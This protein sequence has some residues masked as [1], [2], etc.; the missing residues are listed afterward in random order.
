MLD[1]VKCE[2]LKL[3]RKRFFLLVTVA[4]FVFPIPLTA[5]A[6]KDSI[7]YDTLFK[8]IILY[9]HTL[10]LT[11]IL[12]ISASV[13]INIEKENNTLKNIISIPISKNKIIIGKLIILLLL[14]LCYSVGAFGASLIGAILSSA[15]I[16]MIYEKIGFCII[17]GVL[18]FIASLPCTILILAF[19]KNQIISIILTFFYSIGSF[20][21][22]LTD[23]SSNALNLQTIMPTS[24]VI[25]W[26]IPKLSHNMT[27]D[28][29]IIKYFAINDL[30]C[31]IAM[32]FTFVIS[33]LLICKLYRLQEG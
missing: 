28:A 27:I 22:A 32:T 13:L 18:T 31:G 7:S 2:L 19:G 17:A 15:E 29:N 4:A 20:L 23:V 10:L 21:I 3:K 14:S 33:L 30:Q 9:G 1:I 16:F 6:V 25:R 12:C 5:L 11:P 8:F 24:I 26:I